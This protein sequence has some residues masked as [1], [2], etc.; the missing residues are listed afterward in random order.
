MSAKF[1]GV[2]LLRRSRVRRRGRVRN[3]HSGRG[4]HLLGLEHVVQLVVLAASSDIL[5]NDY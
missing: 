2:T 3:R 4:E 5:G 1:K